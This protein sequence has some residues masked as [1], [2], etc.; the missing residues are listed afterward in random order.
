M[1]SKLGLGGWIPRKPEA[2]PDAYNPDEE[3]PIID[4]PAFRASIKS[5]MFEDDQGPKT[6]VWQSNMHVVMDA[7][8][9]SKHRTE[10][11]STTGFHVRIGAGKSLEDTFTFEEAQK[12]AALY[13]AYERKSQL[14]C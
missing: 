9:D 14:S 7:I 1:A 4:E 11:N 6:A 3:P 5:P 12:I 2:K 10:V 13:L 8:N